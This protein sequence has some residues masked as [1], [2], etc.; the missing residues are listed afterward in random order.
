MNQIVKKNLAL[1]EKMV[2][3]NHLKSDNIK[4]QIKDD[5]KIQKNKIENKFINMVTPNSF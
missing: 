2:K 5:N 1:K 3:T 4:Y